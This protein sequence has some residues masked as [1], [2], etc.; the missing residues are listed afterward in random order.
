[1]ASRKCIQSERSELSD[2]AASEVDL[3]TS[4]LESIYKCNCGFSPRFLSKVYR[5][6]SQMAGEKR[7]CPLCEKK[8]EFRSTPSMRAHSVR[9]HKLEFDSTKWKTIYLNPDARK[10]HFLIKFYK[11]NCGLSSVDPGNVYTHVLKMARAIR[12]CPMCEKEYAYHSK[13]CMR[14]HSLREHKKPFELA[15]W[16]TFDLNPDARKKHFVIKVIDIILIFIKVK[17]KNKFK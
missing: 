4:Y 16:K 5:H 9:K 3:T 12:K 13:D 14:V 11:C 10:E 17:Q 2:E 1:M 8:Y 15:K 6:V 7:Q